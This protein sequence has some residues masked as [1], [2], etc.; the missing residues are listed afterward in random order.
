MTINDVLPTLKGLKRSG[1]G[2]TARCPAHDDRRN[3]LSVSAGAEGQALLHCHAG[4]SYEAIQAALGLGGAG[5][6][7]R[8]SVAA[9]YDYRDEAGALLYQAV[10]FEPKDFRQRKPD[11][12]GG[13]SYKLNGVRRVP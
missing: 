11:G 12:S 7:G 5:G 10:R 8:P 1:E 9:T 13:W 6:T 4:C 2:W 3:S